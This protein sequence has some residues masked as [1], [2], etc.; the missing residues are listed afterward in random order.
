VVICEGE[1]DNVYLVHAIRSLA[2]AFPILAAVVDGKITLKV[3]LYKHS[4]S[5]TARMVDLGDGGS[6]S[7][8]KFISTYHREINK[9]TSP[10]G[11]QPVVILI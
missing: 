3:R 10:G 4:G 7:L 1:T 9:F 8:T 11:Q 6:A 5:R 2:A